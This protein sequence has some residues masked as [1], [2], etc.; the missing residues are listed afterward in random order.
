MILKRPQP[1][2]KR[3]RELL[4]ECGGV[5]MFVTTDVCLCVLLFTH[6]F[7]IKLMPRL[8]KTDPKV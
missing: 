3:R 4:I 1:W 2:L 5:L 6:V 7:Y 8:D